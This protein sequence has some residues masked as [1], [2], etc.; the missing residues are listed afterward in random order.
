MNLGRFGSWLDSRSLMTRRFLDI[1]SGRRQFGFF[2]SKRITIFD[3]TFGWAPFTWTVYSIRV[4]SRSQKRHCQAWNSRDKI[5]VLLIFTFYRAVWLNYTVILMNMMGIWLPTEF[6][7]AFHF[8][9]THHNPPSGCGFPK[10]AQGAILTP[11]LDTPTRQPCGLSIPLPITT[12]EC[13]E[14]WLLKEQLI[15]L[16]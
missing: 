2:M 13:K 15:N 12:G 6:A 4:G 8:W 5:D 3:D 16:L 11:T 7:K 14:S 10:G 1:T 9:K